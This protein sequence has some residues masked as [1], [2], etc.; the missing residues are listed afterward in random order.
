MQI[1]R[2]TDGQTE[3]KRE[4]EVKKPPNKKWKTHK[5]RKL[6]DRETSDQNG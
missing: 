1:D 4:R 3:R 6:I 5:K 2:Y